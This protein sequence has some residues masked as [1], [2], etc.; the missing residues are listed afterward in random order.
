MA[1]IDNDWVTNWASQQQHTDSGS[2]SWKVLSGV[3]SQLPDH[4]CQLGPNDSNGNYT[5]TISGSLVNGTFT[6]NQ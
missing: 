5:F 2:S 1:D 6:I 3:M 4:T